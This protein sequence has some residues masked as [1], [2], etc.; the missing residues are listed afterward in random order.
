MNV[1]SVGGGE[2]SVGETLSIDRHIRDRSGKHAPRTL[3]IP[4]ASG[5]A[6]GYCRSFKEIYHDALGCIT[7]NLL[8]YSSRMEQARIDELIF[9][10]DII[11]VGGGNTKLMLDV[12]RASGVATRLRE[13]A[14]QGTILAGLSAGAIC[15]YGTGLSDSDRFCDDKDWQF[16]IIEG[17]NLIPVMFCPHL[18]VENRHHPLLRA[19]SQTGTTAIACDNG[20]A[21]SWQEGK[22]TVVCSREE[23]RAYI[24]A[25]GSSSEVEVVAMTGGD[26]FELANL[27]NNP[28]R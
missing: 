18:D 3:F 6:H 17:L 13:A 12:W 11:Y 14:R 5:D 7:E 21:I 20:A 1:I 23:A 25:E 19:V 15:W 22:G 2:I 28:F 4:T 8:L 27:L 9:S 24:Y 16:S 10:A 26:S